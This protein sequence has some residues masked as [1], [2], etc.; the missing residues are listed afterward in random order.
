MNNTWKIYILAFATFVVSTSEYVIA[1]I[2]DKIAAWAHISVS[3][4]GQLITVFAIANAIISQIFVMATVK[5]EQR[6][7]LILSLAIVVIG[8]ILTVTLP[9]FSLLT[10]SRITLA[11]GGGVFSITAKTAAS[12]LA[13]PGQQ[14]GAIGTIITGF[15]AALIIGVPIG[16]IVAA[17]YSWQLIFLVIGILS[18]ISIFVLVRIIPDL[19]S[20]KVEAV[21]LGKQF[22]I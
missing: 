20:E 11:I 9:N 17:L 3:A 7:L 8:C 13:P 22:A 12:K 16:R 15:S 10:V 5:I 1:G 21:S 4:A 2:L 6:K 18:L 19:N 14:A